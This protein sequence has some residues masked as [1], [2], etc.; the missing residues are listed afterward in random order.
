[1]RTAVVIVGCCLGLAACTA[2]PTFKPDTSV[3]RPAVGRPVAPSSVQA[4]TSSDAFTPYEDLG[5]ST[6][7]LAPGE[8]FSALSKACL[9]DEG[10]PDAVGGIGFFIAGGPLAGRLPWGPWG[11]LGAAQ[12]AQ[13]GFSF[14]A[15]LGSGVINRAVGQGP[16]SAAEQKAMQKC[17]P[18]DSKF[19]ENES[20]GPLA[21]IQSLTNNIQTDL[22]HDPSVRAASKAW[23]ACMAQNG[24][25]ITDPQTA[26]DKAFGT[27][28]AARGVFII[29]GTQNKAQ[30][31]AQIA[32][33]VTDA[34]C[35]ASTDLAGIYFAVQASYEQQLV[36]ANSQALNA[37]VQEYRTDYQKELSQLPKALGT[38]KASLLASI[39]ADK[40]LARS[41]R[42][43]S[44]R[45][46]PPRRPAVWRTWDVQRSAASS[47]V[48][49]AAG[50]ASKRASGMG[51]PLRTDLP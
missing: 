32:L 35:T 42:R 23:S 44:Q 16:P 40:E 51:V 43:T 29:G 25:N 2:A 6:D 37:A 12:A 9:T 10:F 47:M 4:A 50:S 5:Q 1:M 13:D 7:G 45:G 48:S 19:V 28:G 31:E 15:A 41:S 49:S 18:I 20:R 38:T 3:T 30:Q 46:L 17:D 34:D 8:S 36:N 33:A 11:Y 22:Q 24:Y 14:Q 39:A 21:G 26:V 27:S